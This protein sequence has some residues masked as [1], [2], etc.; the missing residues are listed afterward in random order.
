[1]LDL[2]KDI[3]P[4]AEPIAGAGHDKQKIGQAV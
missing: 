1:M 4:A 2:H 3:D